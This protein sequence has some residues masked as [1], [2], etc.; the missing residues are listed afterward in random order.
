MA[1]ATNHIQSR[2]NSDRFDVQ[3]ISNL[4]LFLYE[5]LL[6][7]IAHCQ[8]DQ[9]IA[10]ANIYSLHEGQDLEKILDHDELINAS[11]TSGRLYLHHQRFTLV[12]GI[13]FNPAHSALYLNF[14]TEV[15]PERDEVVYTGIANNSIQI[16]GAADKALLNLFDARLPEMET[17]H[18]AAHVLDYFLHQNKDLLNQEIFVHT[19]PNCMYVAGFKDSELMLF[20]RF[21]IHEEQ[22]LLR[23]LFTVLQQLAFDQSHCKISIL[24]NLDWIHSSEENL[25]KYFKNI[26]QISPTQNIGYQKGAENLRNTQLLEAFW[27]QQPAV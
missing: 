9:S 24:G 3:D 4:S 25:L 21:I 27:L 10:A 7:V 17:S 19:A 11:N 16:L 6:T 8:S 20:N 18:G 1:E 5:N 26:R 15:N 22:A 14:A 2:F 12:P 23:Y 13:L